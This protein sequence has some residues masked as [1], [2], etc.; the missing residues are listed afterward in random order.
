MERNV[1]IPALIEKWAER[2]MVRDWHVRFLDEEPIPDSRACTSFWGSK[3][4]AVIRVRK[5]APEAVWEECVVHEMIHIALNDYVSDVKNILE[6]A[7]PQCGAAVTLARLDE[8]EEIIIE[9]LTY[10]LL[11]KPVQCWDD[12]EEDTT[13]VRAFPVEP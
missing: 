1:E 7:I 3:R 10:A 4:V 11:G 8:R 6:P 9:K 12:G 5:S 13:F 2:L